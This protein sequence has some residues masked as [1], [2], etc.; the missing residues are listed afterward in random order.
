[1][2]SMHVC[3]CSVSCPSATEHHLC[4][5]NPL[6]LSLSLSLSPS[7]C[8]LICPSLIRSSSLLFSAFKRHPSLSADTSVLHKHTW[9]EIKCESLQE[10]YQKSEIIL[11]WVWYVFCPSVKIK[12]IKKSKSFDSQCPETLSHRNC[13]SNKEK[14]STDDN[15]TVILLEHH[16][17]IFLSAAFS[18]SSVLV[19][20]SV[21][22][23]SW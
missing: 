8:P 19:C 18:L 9:T 13:K 2:Q 17:F 1:M 5:S 3:V 10:P 7:I 22:S 15:I 20:Q 21:I 23:E 12:Q 6:I 11:W 14:K 4:S 16:V